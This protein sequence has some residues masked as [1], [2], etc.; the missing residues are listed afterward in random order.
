MVW[1]RDVT[2]PG[3]FSSWL[4]V[5]VLWLGFGTDRGLV[6]A[7]SMVYLN[8][9]LAVGPVCPVS[10]AV[11][12]SASQGLEGESRAPENIPALKRD[13]CLSLLVPA[14]SVAPFGLSES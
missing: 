2:T 12:C 7:S 6:V 3:T 9:P 10:R 8:R 5:E 14:N 13:I 11:L 4:P 1:K